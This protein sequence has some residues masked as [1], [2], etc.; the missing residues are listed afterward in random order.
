[1]KNHCPDK[2]AFRVSIPIIASRI[3]AVRTFATSLF[4]TGFVLLFLNGC[5]PASHFSATS[6]SAIISRQIANHRELILASDPR[7]RFEGRFDWSD[8]NAP[9]VIWQASRIDLDFAGTELGL[10]FDKPTGQN[11]FNAVVDG[12]NTVVEAS[13][14][15]PVNPPSFGDL[16]PR[17]HRLELF[18][19]S[20]AAAG[21]VR[22]CG[23]TLASGATARATEP[24]A[25]KLKMEFIGDSIT[26]GAC[27]EDGSADQWMNRRTHNSALSY[28]ALTAKAFQADHRNI[29]VSGMGISTGYVPMKAGEVWNRLYPTTNAPLVESA[30][31]IPQIVFVNFGENDNSFTK[32]HGRPFPADFTQGYMELVRAIRSDYP[33]ARIVLLRGGMSG[34][35]KSE[36]LR[37]AWESA[38][39]QLESTDQGTSHFVFQH[40]T[41]TH[42]R[43]SD[44]RIMADELVR[45]LWQQKFIPPNR[46]AP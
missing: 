19:R 11:F 5:A 41:M 15:K 16:G 1:M 31:W 21:H 7:F 30:D 14:G 17:W 3:Q 29:S 37:V 8:S 9:V 2:T 25:Y 46:A 13:E 38:V 40:W 12:S 32:V 39:T 44:D 4:R 20:E 42:P 27:N 10:C 43:V 22:F 34:G 28:A 6:T 35:A 36:P 45:W 23:V 26:V 18:K 24:P 33:E